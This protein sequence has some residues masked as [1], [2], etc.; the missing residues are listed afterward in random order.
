MIILLTNDDGYQAEG[1]SVLETVLAEAGHEVWVCA[2]SDQRSAQSHAMTLKGKIR[3]IRFDARHYHCSGTPADCILYGL[4]GGALPVAP[5][6]VVSGINHGYNASTDIL[7]SGTVGAASE[8]A[9]RGIPAIAIS[10][11]NDR[12]TGEF[13]FIKAASFLVEHLEE[14]VPLCTRDV[15]LNIN[16]PPT[17]TGQWRVGKIGQLEYFDVVE[18]S[19]TMRATSYDA[20]STKIG[21][22]Y[23]DTDT[24]A[25]G[26]GIGEEVTLSLRGEVPPELRHPDMETDYRLLGENFIS[27]TPILVHPVVDMPT[28]ARLEKLQEGV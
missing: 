15:M 6:V 22:A 23:G 18:R 28:V 8:A 25:N 24:D 19:S 16:V 27:V 12:Q 1:I 11:R 5:D 3:F 4:N 9:L 7:Y 17:N 2:P 21:L 13:P 14:F 20:S 26:V 10:A